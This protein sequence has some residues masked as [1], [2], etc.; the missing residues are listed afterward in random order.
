[1]LPHGGVVT[2]WRGYDVR[3]GDAGLRNSTAEYSCTLS[4][5]ASRMRQ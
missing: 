2:M 3:W 1:M 5:E 4:S